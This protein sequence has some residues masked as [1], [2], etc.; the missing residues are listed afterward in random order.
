MVRKKWSFP[1]KSQSCQT[2]KTLLNKAYID[3]KISVLQI[4]GWQRKQIVIYF[5]HLQL[6]GIGDRVIDRQTLLKEETGSLP[7]HLQ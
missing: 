5:S 6:L 3:P 2:R 4:K 7:V 1:Q